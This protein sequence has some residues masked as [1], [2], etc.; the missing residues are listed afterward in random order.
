MASRFVENLDEVL[1]THP[2]LNVSLDDILAEEGRK[3][4]SS[5]SSH[6]SYTP[7]SGSDSAAIPVSPASES[8]RNT[9]KR[10]AMHLGSNKGR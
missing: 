8:K 2:H 4:S 10:R 1:I 9:L 7:R 5:Q 3:R 6:T